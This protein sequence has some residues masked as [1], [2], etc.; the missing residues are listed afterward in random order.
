MISSQLTNWWAAQAMI[1]SHTHVNSVIAGTS[2]QV[3]GPIG[4]SQHGEGIN[5]APFQVEFLALDA[6][7]EEVAGAIKAYT[8]KPR[9]NFVLD[10]FHEERNPTD[11]ADKYRTFGLEYRRTESIFGVDLPQDKAGDKKIEIHR[12]SHVEELATVNPA[13]QLEGETIAASTVDN[14]D[15]RNYYA[16]LDEKIAGWAQLVTVNEEAGY[17]SQLYTL[18]AYRRR[19]IGLALIDRIHSA[20]WK[21]G[22][23][24]I[25]LIPS[26]IGKGLYAKYGYR[27][28][29]YFS[30]FRPSTFQE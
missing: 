3:R 13:L 27:P 30:V 29:L 25:L 28:L 6:D 19:G 11:L 21:M 1:D 7:P 8:P 20:G 9:I 10:V 18:T 14:E 26:E 23:K 17:V 16:V 22:K 5:D 12:V 24:H 4:V 15:I 2:F